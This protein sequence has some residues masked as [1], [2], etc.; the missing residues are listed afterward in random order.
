MNPM[1]V[2]L[3]FGVS[4]LALWLPWAW[5]GFCVLRQHVWCGECGGKEQRVRPGLQTIARLK[6]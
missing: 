6:F 1:G 2:V 4:R 3:T 5:W